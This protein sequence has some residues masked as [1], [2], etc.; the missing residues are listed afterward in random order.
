ME[1]SHNYFQINCITNQVAILLLLHPQFNINRFMD[2]KF[3]NLIIQNSH[4]G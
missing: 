4:D 2:I 1:L 3:D